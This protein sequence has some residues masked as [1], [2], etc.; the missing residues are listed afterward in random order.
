MT[1]QN[2]L[3]A[4]TIQL[5]PHHHILFPNSKKNVSQNR[6]HF[7]QNPSH[8]ATISTPYSL[9]ILLNLPLIYRSAVSYP[10]ILL[11]LS[12]EKKIPIS[13]DGF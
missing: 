3:L 11:P 13:G 5:P 8:A 4:N 2:H 10:I 7:A 12:G 6:R 9:F 1:L